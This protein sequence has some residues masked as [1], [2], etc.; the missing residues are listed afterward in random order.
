MDYYKALGVARNCSPE[1][2]K[3]VYRKLA[4]KYH[5]DRTKGDKEAEE[6]F[7][8]ISEAYA[9]LSDK[10]KR[11]QYDTFGAAGFQQRYSQEDIFRNFDMNSILREFGVN[12]GSAA[13]GAG[14]FR[15]S[16][17]GSPFEA[18]FQQAG[19][20]SCGSGGC[21]S[22]RAAAPGKGD[23]LQMELPVTLEEILTGVE[24]TISLRVGSKIERVSVK[25]PAG[26][27]HGKKLRI[28]GKG[29]PSPA[30]GL[31]GD[32]FLRIKEEPHLLFSREENNL[33]LEKQITFSEA[34]LGTPIPVVTLDGKELQVKA[35]PGTQSH[36]RLRLKEK[37]LP[38]GPHGPRGD[39]YIKIIVAVPRTLTDEQREMLAKLAEVGL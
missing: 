3:K 1:E 24:K 31:T 4:L 5:P 25:V 19:G 18:F 14:N 33:I 30:G 15:S 36:S 16:M 8:Q 34:A 26:I 17:G 13:G 29:S 27:E 2:I 11:Q 21:Q 12:F 28:P 22:G 35:P 10:E 7:K 23:D 20:S 9:V 38:S 37:G 39:L 6:R 32:L